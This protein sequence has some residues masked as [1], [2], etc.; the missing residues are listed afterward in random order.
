M[1]DLIG[2]AN[3]PVESIFFNKVE[4]LY[5]CPVHDH[6]AFDFYNDD[7][8]LEHV[9]D[10]LPFREGVYNVRH[11][12]YRKAMV[13]LPLVF[14]EWSPSFE[15]K[16]IHVYRLSAVYSLLTK[17]QLMFLG[18]KEPSECNCSELDKQ[19]TGNEPYVYNL[20]KAIQSIQDEADAFTASGY[21]VHFNTYGDWK[22]SDMIL[23][24]DGLAPPAN[25]E[26]YN[27]SDGQR[28]A[29]ELLRIFP[30]QMT[31]TVDCPMKDVHEPDTPIDL[32]GLVSKGEPLV[33]P[34][35]RSGYL[36]NMVQ[37]INDEHK[38]TLP[39][40]AD[41]L[42]EVAEVMDLDLTFPTPEDIPAEPGEEKIRESM[43][44]K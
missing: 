39:E 38:W 31:T 22:P 10:I 19:I 20:Q 3:T 9:Y 18:P 40:I 30:D 29:E 28:A 13:P 27:P 24:M 14:G 6:V 11:I 1:L 23:N 32:L 37:H 5:F 25:P 8:S 44:E 43:E 34:C 15:E 12:G 35:R 4:E 21:P 42:D 2:V 7:P 17:P 33:E 36:W 26:T 16:T 41:W